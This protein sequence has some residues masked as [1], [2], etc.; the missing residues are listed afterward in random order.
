MPLGSPFPSLLVSGLQTLHFSS[1]QERP[2]PNGGVRGTIDQKHLPWPDTI[3]NTCMRDLKSEVVVKNAELTRYCQLEEFKNSQKERGNSS[4]NVQ[5]ISQNPP[6]GNPSWK[7][8]TQPPGR[9]LSQN[10]WPGLEM[11]PITIAPKTVS[12]V[13]EQFSFSPLGTPS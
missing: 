3:V 4:P 13:A 10:D 2:F 8:C 5:A 1:K 12:H 6:R 7:R 9:T 11:H